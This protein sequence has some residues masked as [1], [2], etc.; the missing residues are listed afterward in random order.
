[1]T[2]RPAHPVQPRQLLRML[3]L[4][5]ADVVLVLVGALAVIYQIGFFIEEVVMRP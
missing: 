4:V 5:L 1:M 2:H 3:L